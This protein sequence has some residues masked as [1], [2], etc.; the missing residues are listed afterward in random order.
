MLDSL[1]KREFNSSVTF[2]IADDEKGYSEKG[3]GFADDSVRAYC[4]Q[5]GIKFQ[6]RSPHTKEQN[7]SAEQ[8]GKSVIDKARS[9]RVTSN[10]PLALA[11]ETYVAAGYLLN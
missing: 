8:S 4:N 3:Y 9:M 11:P 5:E 7:G 6:L 1:I 2:L 10:L